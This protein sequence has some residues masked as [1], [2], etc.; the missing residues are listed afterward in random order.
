M[1][2]ETLSVTQHSSCVTAPNGE[3]LEAYQYKSQGPEWRVVK[4]CL[5]SIHK[6]EHTELPQ[7][8]EAVGMREQ[9]D[10]L[11]VAL[12]HMVTVTV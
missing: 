6:W 1:L 12:S 5:A 3:Q 9:C 11:K 7:E 10:T 8:L 4:H 2:E